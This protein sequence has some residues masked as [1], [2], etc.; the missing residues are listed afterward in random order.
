[1][2]T[3]LA[4]SFSAN[5]L[6]SVW[7]VFGVS[8]A[9]DFFGD[10]LYYGLGRLGRKNLVDRYGRYIG[11]APSH[12]SRVEYYVQ[13]NF[14]KAVF[15]A[16]VSHAVGL[17][18]LFVVGMLRLRL[19]RFMGFSLLIG[20][21]KTAAFVGIGYFFGG[22]YRVIGEYL[23]VGASAVVFF[24]SLFIVYK[25]FRYASLRKNEYGA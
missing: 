2:A 16:K 19:G 7:G 25:I 22:S 13:Q 1:M 9:G 17:A 18:I 24:V 6:M 8:L 21:P 5:G 11:V 3:I 14:F 20:I 15:A 10:L 4:A 12:I 23:N